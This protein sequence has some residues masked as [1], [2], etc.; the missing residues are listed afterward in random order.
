VEIQYSEKAVKQ[1]RKIHKGNRKSAEIIL[2]TIE[3]YASSPYGKFDVKTLKGNFG[4]LKRLRAGNF[5]VL[6]DNSEN[7]MH[8]YEVKDRK[9]AYRD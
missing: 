4:N 5:R 2:R 7:T 9:E 6:F 8:V 3:S 1:I